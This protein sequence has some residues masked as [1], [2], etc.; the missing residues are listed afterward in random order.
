MSLELKLLNALKADEKKEISSPSEKLRIT[1]GA[2]EKAKTYAKLVTILAGSGMECYGYLLKDKDA[3]D[4]TVKDIYFADDQDTSSAHVR[5]TPEGVKKAGEEAERRNSEIVGW[6]HSHGTL[7]VFHSSWDK[8]NFEVI[9]HEIATQTMYRKELA[10]YVVKNGRVFFDDYAVDGLKLPEGNGKVRIMKKVERQPFAWS[11]VVNVREEVY[12][13]C[14]T[15]TYNKAENRFELNSPTHPQLDVITVDNDVKF[16][17]PDMEWEIYQKVR[18]NNHRYDDGNGNDYKCRQYAKI[19]DKFYKSALSYIEADGKYS[20]FVASLMLPGCNSVA[21]ALKESKK[22]K[23]ETGVKV[24][25]LKAGEDEIKDNLESMIAKSDY[26]RY[27]DPNAKLKKYELENLLVLQMMVGFANKADS[28]SGEELVKEQDKAVE[29]YSSR[30]SILEDCVAIAENAVKSLPRYAMEIY[31][32]YKCEKQHKYRK[33][34]T[35]ILA[36]MSTQK[37]IP[38][39]DAVKK[40]TGKYPTEGVKKQFFLYQDRMNIFNQLV[41]DLF[42]IRIGKCNSEYNFNVV[43]FLN[44]FAATYVTDNDKSDGIIEKYVLPIRVKSDELTNYTDTAIE[45]Y[46]QKETLNL[47]SILK[48]VRNLVPELRGVKA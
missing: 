7:S 32:D 10:N 14:I 40:E 42:Y 47:R 31:T 19:A 36:N 24:S 5:V 38:F 26:R 21:G 4:D 39:L 25:K 22:K 30:V 11:M 6:T 34:M 20:N 1:K 16:D 15:K 29:L 33:L 48:Y 13:E 17:I 9:L 46:D 12:K 18:M 28:Y 2:F 27:L 41:K 37:N 43:G 45:A 3:L 35:N 23:E 8:D 44:E